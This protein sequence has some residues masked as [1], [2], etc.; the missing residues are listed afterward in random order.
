MATV[1]RTPGAV[2]A[3]LGKAAV[4]GARAAPPHLLRCLVVSTAADRRRLIREAAEAQTWDAIVC[5]DAGEFLRVAFKRSVP[6]IIVDLPQD[7]SDDYWE[8]REAADRAKQVARSL[9]MIAGAGA[10]PGEELWARGLGAWA[11]VSEVRLQRGFEFVLS[12]A[13]E[14]IARNSDLLIASYGSADGSE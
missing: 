13:R 4:V 14:A 8:L 6:L 3:P 12:E 1:N 11:Y 5:R 9:L 10:E 7:A 2:V